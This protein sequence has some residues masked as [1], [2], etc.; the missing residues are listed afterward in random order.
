MRILNRI[1]NI[2]ILLA[3]IAAVVFSYMLF[4]KREK[5]VDGWDQMAKAIS[6]TAKTID[7][8]GASGTKAALELADDKLK[9]TNYEQLAQILP[10][11]KENTEKIVAQRNA[12]ADSVQQAAT[13]LS[14]Q[15]IDS[16]EL[17]NIASYQDKERAFNSKVQE[18]RNV[19]DKVSEGY[20]E[21][22]RLAGGDVNSSEFNGPT[23]YSAAIEKVNSAVQDVVT[24]RN[25]YAN[26]VSQ[27]V[28]TIGIQAP[29][30]T[31]KNYREEFAKTL[32][33]V[34]A[35]RQEFVETKNQLDSEKSK[36]LRLTN[37][38]ET[39][40]KTISAHLA[41]LRTQKNKIDELT[42]ILT[43][44]G[45]IQLP[46]VLLTGKEPEC[47]KYVKG[48]IEYIDND[49]GF[50]TIDIGK[51]YTFT[52]RYGIKDNKVPF[53]LTPGKIM[54]VARGLN[55]NQPVFVG[56]VFVTKVEDN[57]AICNLM[58]GKPSDFKVGDTVY[59]SDDDIN[60][61]LGNAKQSTA[62]K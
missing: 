62:K 23:T 31:D 7:A 18:F 58:G 20:S 8:G 26:Y 10:K 48:T 50:V 36:A 32:K 1:I 52:Q 41:S 11:L 12:L 39:H 30:L 24:R 5:L 44:D 60:A 42:N 55:T 61:A 51:N 37:E 34:Q 9:H 4:S 33:S 53:P 15:G 17:K 21:T 57:S 38:V 22:A 13:T 19:R 43:K 6:A 2:L 45:S 40:K 25:D 59:F 56:K 47:Y 16:K 54:T 14:I 49:F 28:R 35:Y 27:I 29:R 3:A 46:P